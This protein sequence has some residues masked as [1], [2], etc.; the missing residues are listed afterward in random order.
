MLIDELRALAQQAEKT[1]CVVGIWLAGQDP[2]LQAVITELK[3]K[4][5]LNMMSV[6]TLLKQDSD[7][8]FKATSF[9][10]HMRGRCACQTA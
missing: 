9:R 4:P 6:L 10:D 1:G 8:R 7:V 3:S 2:E 5:N